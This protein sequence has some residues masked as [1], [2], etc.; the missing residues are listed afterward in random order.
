MKKRGIAF[1]TLIPWLIAIAVLAAIV[2]FA[3]LLRG[4]L[5][6][7]GSYIKNLFR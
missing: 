4:R 6:E 2:V 5:V 7:M 1:E 3:V